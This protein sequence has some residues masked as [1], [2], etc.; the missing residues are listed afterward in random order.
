MLRSD[1]RI[2]PTLQA[3]RAGWDAS[4]RDG[5]R[6]WRARQPD[7]RAVYRGVRG[8]RGLRSR[9]GSLAR[10]A[11]AVV[12][13]RLHQGA[14][15]GVSDAALLRRLVLPRHALRGPASRNSPALDVE[16]I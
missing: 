5:S 9:W 12:F 4:L 16:V 14:V 11:A 10:L 7:W 1:N 6:A 15:F 8:V 13:T 3:R 2:S